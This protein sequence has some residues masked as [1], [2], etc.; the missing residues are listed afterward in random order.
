MDEL[1]DFLDTHPEI[2]P[3]LRGEFLELVA[4]TPGFAEVLIP[5]LKNVSDALRE[6][7]AESIEK[8]MEE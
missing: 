5:M 3:L 6:K 8:R 4:Q 7:L 1:I 2:K